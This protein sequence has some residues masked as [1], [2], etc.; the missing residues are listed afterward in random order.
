LLR[1]HLGAD[2]DAGLEQL[3]TLLDGLSETPATDFG[4]VFK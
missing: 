4:T 3:A 1:V 2:V